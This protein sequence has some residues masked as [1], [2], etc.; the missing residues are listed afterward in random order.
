MSEFDDMAHDA[1]YRG[2]EAKQ[3]AA[4]IEDQER[5]RV[6]EEDADKLYLVGCPYCDVFVKAEARS[7]IAHMQKAHPEIIQQRLREA[8][9][10][11]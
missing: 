6:L 1:G 11:P 2:D 5:Q 8:G 7:E 10:I 4:M 9:E 3:V